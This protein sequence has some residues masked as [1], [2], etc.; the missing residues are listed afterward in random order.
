MYEILRRIPVCFL[1]HHSIL[2]KPHLSHHNSFVGHCI[3]LSPLISL[4][5]DRGAK[6]LREEDGGAAGGEEDSRGGKH[7]KGMSVRELSRLREAGIGVEGGMEMRETD[8][9]GGD[10]KKILEKLMDQD[11]EE[12]E[13]SKILSIV[14]QKRCYMHT[15]LMYC[16][17]RQM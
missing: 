17:N 6:R 10:K 15:L 5:P 11:E 13:V 7:Q 2:C 1:F 14:T 8:D 4:Q 12:P 16:M 9:L 3:S